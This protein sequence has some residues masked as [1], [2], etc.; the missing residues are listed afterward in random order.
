MTV[1]LTSAAFP[2]KKGSVPQ[3][4]IRHYSYKN[5][6]DQ[7]RTGVFIGSSMEHDCFQSWV[8]VIDRWVSNAV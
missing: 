8:L 1:W 3:K 7:S 6:L 2:A 5:A 4:L